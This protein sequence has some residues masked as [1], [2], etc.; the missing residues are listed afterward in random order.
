MFNHNVKQ[1]FNYF[2]IGIPGNWLKSS[3]GYSFQNCFLYSKLITKNIIDNKKIKI[4]N[5]FLLIFLDEVFC[6]LIMKSSKDLKIFFLYFFKKNNLM[7]IVKFL[8]GNINFFQLL[9]VII[10]LPKKKIFISAFEVIKKEFYIM[11]TLELKIF[12]FSIFFF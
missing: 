1:Q 11:K 9:R 3:T 6:N 7:L 2:P 8:N 12:I 4:K 10:T 5:N